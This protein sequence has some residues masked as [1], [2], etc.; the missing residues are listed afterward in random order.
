[1]TDNRIINQADQPNSSDEMNEQ[2]Y[3]QFEMLFKKK[4]RQEKKK[5]EQKK[6]EELYEKFE[7][8]FKRRIDFIRKF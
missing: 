1:M 5:K 8:P 2:E 4:E 7:G 3:Q 6:K